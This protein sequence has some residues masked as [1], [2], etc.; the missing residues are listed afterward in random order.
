MRLC[1]DA[2][3]VKLCFVLV[4]AGSG[5]SP[6]DGSLLIIHI[7]GPGLQAVLDGVVRQRE[8]VVGVGARAWIVRIRVLLHVVDHGSVEVLPTCAEAKRSLS[9]AATQRRGIL[10]R[11]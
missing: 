5:N 9:A 6:L 7:D 2:K 4:S 11:G 8:S 1:I 3:L 10:E